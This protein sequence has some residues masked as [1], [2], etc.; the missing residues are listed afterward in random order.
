MARRKKATP[1]RR[2][3]RRR[4]VGAVGMSGVSDALF[5]IGGA[6][7]GHFI[8]KL[9]PVDKPAIKS[10]IVLGAGIFLPKFIKNPMLSKMAPGLVAYGGLNLLQNTGILKGVPMLGGYS[11]NTLP[12]SN[13]V[14]GLPA[15]TAI[16]GLPE[17]HRANFAAKATA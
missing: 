12:E 11:Y 9:I 6:A 7:V 3:S 17:Y 4:R 15:N 16:S 8:S 13:M 5:V 14:A 10:A 1:K 2:T